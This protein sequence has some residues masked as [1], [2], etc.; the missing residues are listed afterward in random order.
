MSMILRHHDYVL[1]FGALA[2]GA[3]QFALRQVMDIDAPFVLTAIGGYEKVD[4]GG[5]LQATTLSKLLQFRYADADGNWLQN[6][7]TPGLLIQSVSS[8]YNPLTKQVA[9]PAGGAIQ[10]RIVN[11]GGSIADGYV[12]FRGFKIFPGNAD[13]GN[14]GQSVVYAPTY[15]A[16][17]RQ[18][19]F[20]WAINFDLA[21]NTEQLNIPVRV[22]DDADFACRALTVAVNNTVASATAGGLEVRLK[23]PLGKA[24]S[25][26]YMPVRWLFGSAGNNQG[27]MF[28]E[29]YW[30]RNANFSIDLRNTNTAAVRNAVQLSFSGCKVVP[31]REG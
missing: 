5:I 3:G 9:Y 30:K 27:L 8:Y 13:L 24:Y 21:Q 22:L 1:P 28:P 4:D 2:S 16:C 17:Y 7:D 20:D 6:T 11:G 10:C 23:D 19:P 29:L 25:N 26:Q 18:Y 14:A 31:V 12:V 15:P